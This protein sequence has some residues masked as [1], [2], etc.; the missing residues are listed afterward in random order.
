MPGNTLEEE[1]SRGVVATVA[2]EV[3]TGDVE[4]EEGGE[5]AVADTVADPTEKSNTHKKS[6]IFFFATL[7]V[8]ES[9]YKI[10]YIYI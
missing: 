8:S 5:P 7:C 3:A 1:A 10:V 6:S 9:L 4:D 2:A